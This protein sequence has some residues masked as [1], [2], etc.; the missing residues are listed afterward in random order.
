VAQIELAPE[1]GDDLDPIFDHLAHQAVDGAAV[2]ISVLET[3]PLIGRPAANDLRELIIGKRSR[4]YV[5][6]YRYVATLDTV[7]VLALRSQREAG[8]SHA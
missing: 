2:H 3:S 7:F 8:Y 4:G 1:V 5:A 6:L